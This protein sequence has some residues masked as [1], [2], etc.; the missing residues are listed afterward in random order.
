MTNQCIMF[1]Q[2]VFASRL[3]TFPF[4]INRSEKSEASYSV[5]AMSF[6]AYKWKIHFHFMYTHRSC[7]TSGLNMKVNVRLTL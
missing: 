5:A 2:S 4:D 3:P 7:R 6:S 1:G